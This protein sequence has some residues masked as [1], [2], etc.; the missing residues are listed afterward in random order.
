MISSGIFGLARPDI[1][2]STLDDVSLG[3]NVE[4]LTLTDRSLVTEVDVSERLVWRNVQLMKTVQF[5]MLRLAE[6]VPRK[7]VKFC[8]RKLVRFLFFS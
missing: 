2:P 7:V 1:V 3:P 4:L 6:N 8:R 5:G